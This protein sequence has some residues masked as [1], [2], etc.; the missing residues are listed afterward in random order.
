LHICAISIIIG[1]VHTGHVG[2]ITTLSFNIYGAIL[3][4]DMPLRIFE[5]EY[6]QRSKNK[7]EQPETHMGAE[8]L[9]GLA[10]NKNWEQRVGRMATAGP[11]RQKQKTAANEPGKKIRCRETG[12]WMRPRVCSARVGMDSGME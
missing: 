9:V 4:N 6:D 7:F 1:N 12:R 3:S 10:C 5:V 8:W 2:F 11:A